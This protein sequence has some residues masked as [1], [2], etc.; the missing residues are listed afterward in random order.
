MLKQMNNYTMRDTIKLYSFD[1]FDTLITR[2]TGKPDGIF[3]LMQN[4]LL[5]DSNDIPSSIQ[6]NFYD[7]RTQSEAYLRKFLHVQDILF[8]DI[9]RVIGMNN[10]LSD[11]QIN[12]LK[13]LE[14]NTEIRNIIGIQSNIDLVKSLIYDDKRVVLISDMYHT[15]D[16]IR[17]MLCGIDE[18][19]QD[20][21]IYMSS[22]YLKTKRSGEL[23]KLI[24]EKEKIEYSEWM[25]TGDNLVSDV[26]VPKTLGIHSIQYIYESLKL[27]ENKI[28]NNNNAYLQVS[29][30]AARNAR[31]FDCKHNIKMEFGASFGGPV[32]FPYVSW[33]LQE[34]I[35][36]NIKRLYFIARDGYILKKIADII[37]TYKNYELE[38]HYIYGS[39]LAW[40]YPIDNDLSCLLFGHS[41]YSLQ[42][43]SCALHVSPEELQKYFPDIK[44]L[45]GNFDGKRIQKIIESNDDFISFIGE[46]YKK[47]MSLLVRYLKQEINFASDDFAFVEFH[48][49]GLTQECLNNII[50]TFYQCPIRT[51]F[52]S[53]VNK[54]FSTRSKIYTFM[55]NSYGYNFLEPLL[56]AP[57]G[58]TIGYSPPPP[59][60]V[61]NFAPLGGERRG[62]VCGRG[63]GGGC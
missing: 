21:P 12:Y 58:Q 35:R 36:K 56:R 25:H 6:E 2:N 3:Y 1:I 22:E 28:I 42:T 9:Y 17:K 20:I 33:V 41:F 38:T 63:C 32:F 13:A 26:S 4:I 57:H 24:Y 50:G 23:Y 40:R 45:V 10:Q 43:L 54:P 53:F 55:P 48:G 46:R 11:I 60:G 37:I 34:A 59:R 19:F 15:S 61:G 27:Y 49:T 18:I 29:I 39:R 51:F 8:D 62:W 47:D 44:K 7:L 31:L 30:G 16:T 5:K 14:I 52:F